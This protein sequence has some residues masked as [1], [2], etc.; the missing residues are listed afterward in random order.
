MAGMI[1]GLC[2]TVVAREPDRVLIDVSGVRYECFV[3]LSTLGDIGEEGERVELITYLHVREDALVLYGFSTMREKRL[4][5]ALIG[6]SG[7]GPK[8]ASTILSGLPVEDL[9]QAVV[10]GNLARI[11]S[12][13]GVG[14]KMGERMIL[15]LAEPLKKLMNFDVIDAPKPSGL[16][17]EAELISALIN[18]GYKEKV[19]RKLVDRLAET[20]SPDARFE[21][22]IRAALREMQ[23]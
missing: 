6:V 15:E 4:F 19:V 9:G 5:K 13:P 21:D 22:L 14:K 7:I 16:A 1:A 8:L 3:S 12:I 23:S 20:F 2:G 11:T 10:S 18:L 17:K